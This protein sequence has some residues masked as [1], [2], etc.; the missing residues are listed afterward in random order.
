MISRDTAYKMFREGE[1]RELVKLLRE[2]EMSAI[3]KEKTA[4]REAIACNHKIKLRNEIKVSESVN[5]T[6]VICIDGK[7]NQGCQTDSE[8][9]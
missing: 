5:S 6:A 4:Q 7:P 1:G 9:G 2:A 8:I 3:E